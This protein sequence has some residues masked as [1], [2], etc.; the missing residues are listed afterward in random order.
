MGAGAHRPAHGRVPGGGDRH[1]LDCPAAPSP[2]HGVNH[3]FHSSPARMLSTDTARQFRAARQQPAA[4]TLR[5]ERSLPGD[6]C[7]LLAVW[8]ATPGA[9]RP[10]S[11]SR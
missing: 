10:R 6:C 5:A 11:P 8:P 2:P 4:A 9:V 3:Q 7:I 1:P